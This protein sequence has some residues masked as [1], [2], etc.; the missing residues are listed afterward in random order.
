MLPES[1][2]R[3]QQGS[4]ALRQLGHT[5]MILALPAVVLLAVSVAAPKRLLGLVY[6]AKLPTAAPAFGTLVL[7]MVCLC[8]TVVLTVYLLGVG[9]H[10]VVL[11]LGLGTGA[12]IL[13]TI[14][15]HGHYLATARADLVTQAALALALFVSLMAV[16]RRSGRHWSLL[17]G[18]EDEEEVVVAG[19]EVPWSG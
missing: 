5:L 12:L 8:V 11:L 14:H 6:Q 16:H 3:W 10:W 9:W 15:A 18:G 19:S 13:V 4:H 2:I 17:E 7:A 1:A